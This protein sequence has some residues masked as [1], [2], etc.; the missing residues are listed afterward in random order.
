MQNPNTWKNS[1]TPE[2]PPGAPQDTPWAEAARQGGHHTRVAE[3]E[4]DGA[5]CR[6]D[7]EDQREDAEL[8]FLAPA[9]TRTAPHPG[10]CS[11]TAIPNKQTH[12]KILREELV[13]T[14]VAVGPSGQAPP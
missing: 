7:L 3:A 4:P 12:V 11:Q 8:P 6:A 14:K 9:A 2:H 10:A 13:R 1:C 5:V